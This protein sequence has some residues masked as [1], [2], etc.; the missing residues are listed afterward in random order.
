MCW[1]VVEQGS[2]A[3]PCGL[4]GPLVGL[5]QQAFEFGEH[6]LDRIEIGRV[7]RQEEQLD[8][9]RPEQLAH[10]DAFVAAEVVDDDDAAW[11]EFGDEKLLDPGSEALAID[12][13]VDHAGRDDA[14]VLQAGDEGQRLP[15][16]VRHLVDQRLALRAPAVGAGHV[17]LGPGLLDED[18][19]PNGRRIYPSLEREPAGTASH[20]VWTVLLLGKDRL[21]LKDLPQRLRNRHNV[22]QHTSTPRSARSIASNTWSVTS[23]SRSIRAISQSRSPSSS[24]RM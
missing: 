19:A 11:L 7:G 15:V 1:E 24:G 2:D 17:G 10:A 6:L 22:S 21:F 16:S 5:A 23:G 14:V 4:D 20:D 3:A 9:G 18:H 12:R 13:P 8:P